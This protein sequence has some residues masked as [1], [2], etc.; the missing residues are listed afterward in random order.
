MTV[1]EHCTIGMISVTVDT[2]VIRSEGDHRATRRYAVVAPVYDPAILFKL[3]KRCVIG[4]Y[5]SAECAA[6][7]EG[8]KVICYRVLHRGRRRGDDDAHG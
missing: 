8:A 6:T 5:R 3:Y 4:I 7:G 2:H 1:R